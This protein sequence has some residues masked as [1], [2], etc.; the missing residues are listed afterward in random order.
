[1]EIIT[2]L[3]VHQIRREYTHKAYSRLGI[4]AEKWSPELGFKANS[5]P[6]LSF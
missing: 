1:M 3:D 6:Y 5:F 4:K 2:E